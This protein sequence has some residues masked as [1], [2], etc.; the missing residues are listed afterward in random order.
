MLSDLAIPMLPSS[1][2]DATEAFYAALGFQATGRYPDYLLLRR[3]TL[4]LHFAW[5]GDDPEMEFDARSNFAGAYLRVA[6]ADVLH[7]EWAAIE[8]TAERMDEIED[9]PWG[10]REFHVVDPDGNLL[11]IGQVIS[12][13]AA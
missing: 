5:L 11:R 6:D 10:L 8:A 4:E 1:D 12:Q 3:G 13:N 9:K 7:A 2:L